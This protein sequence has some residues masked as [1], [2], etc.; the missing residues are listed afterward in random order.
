[1]FSGRRGIHCWVC[2]EVARK[3]DTAGRGAIAE[4]LNLV[5]GGAEKN[6]SVV[7]AREQIHHSIV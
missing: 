1:M 4:Y 5:K 3:L 6:K 7:L 2:D